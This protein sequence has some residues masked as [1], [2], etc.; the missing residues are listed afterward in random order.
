MD[1]FN[2]HLFLVIKKDCLKQ[3]KDNLLVIK[4]FILKKYY[5]LFIHL[6]MIEVTLTFCF[7]VPSFL[8]CTFLLLFQ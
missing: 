5:Q 2:S 4:L 7:F 1:I 3:N 8:Q 6:M